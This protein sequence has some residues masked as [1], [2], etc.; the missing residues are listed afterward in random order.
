MAGLVPAAGAARDDH[1]DILDAVNLGVAG[2]G[3]RHHHH[4][5][6]QRSVAFLDRVHL[7]Q[8]IAKRLH[9]EARQLAAVDL[10]AEFGVRGLVMGVLVIDLGIAGDVGF[11]LTRGVHE[12]EHLGLVACHRHR[13]QARHRLAV[14]VDHVD[15]RGFHRLFF[16][17]GRNGARLGPGGPLQLDGELI[18]HLTQ[19][20]EVL[21]ELHLVGLADLREQRSSLLGDT[22]QHALIQ[23]DARVRLPV[24]AVWV[25]K[26]LAK[27]PLI[28]CDRRRLRRREA[29]AGVGRIADRFAVGRNLD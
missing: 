6:Q 10:V 28:E 24:R 17:F 19:R 14:V 8:E 13:E 25:L 15:R 27:Q 20:C 4:V 26:A 9:H 7:G 21:V 29:A 1:R 12:V 11:G 23:H 16:G 22:G 3:E 5:V 2:V 18:F